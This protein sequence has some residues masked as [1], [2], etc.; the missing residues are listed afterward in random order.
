MRTILII[1]ALAALAACGQ[2]S[3][4]TESTTTDAAAPVAAPASALT[5]EAALAS[6]QAAGYTDVVDLAPNPDGT[7]SATGTKD[8]AAVQITIND[9]GAQP[10]VPLQ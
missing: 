7:W 5:E 8:G 2:P 9:T 4:T 1:A 3:S 10:T 6:A